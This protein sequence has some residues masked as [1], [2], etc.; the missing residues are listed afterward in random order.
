VLIAEKVGV[1]Q[2]L[3]LGEAALPVD[4]ND[5][6]GAVCPAASWGSSGISASPASATQ[7]RPLANRAQMLGTR[8]DPMVIVKR[9]G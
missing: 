7:A 2:R 6:P 9:G 8:S 1:G 3:G 5:A 4:D